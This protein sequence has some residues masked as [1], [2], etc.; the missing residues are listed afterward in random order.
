[1]HK[2]INFP[3]EEIEKLKNKALIITT[4]IS[5]EYNRY[6]VKE[7]VKTPWDDT[8]IIIK[9]EKINDV[10]KH[11]YYHELTHKQIQLISKY[12]KIAVLTLKKHKSS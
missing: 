8:Y 7:I 1:M 3:D 10:K 6:S 9:I 2:K 5:Q 11:P 4:R 12:K